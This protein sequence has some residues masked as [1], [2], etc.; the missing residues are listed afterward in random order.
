MSNTSIATVSDAKKATKNIR[1]S[2]IN[3]LIFWTSKY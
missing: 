3:K 1:I 2:N